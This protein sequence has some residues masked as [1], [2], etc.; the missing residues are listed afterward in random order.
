MKFTSEIRHKPVDRTLPPDA[1]ENA[2]E[3]VQQVCC[4]HCGRPGMECGSVNASFGLALALGWQFRFIGPEVLIPSGQLVRVA[5]ILDAGIV[6][7]FCPKCS[8]CEFET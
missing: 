5:D 7:V 2:P 1:L 3:L 8:V 4:E 6:E